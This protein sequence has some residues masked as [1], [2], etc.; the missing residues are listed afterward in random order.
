M[1]RFG[2]LVRQPWLFWFVDLARY[3]FFLIE[4]D[5]LIVYFYFYFYHI[6]KKIVSE[7]IFY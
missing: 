7:K 5:Y 2:N 6:V 1:T 3:F 4:L